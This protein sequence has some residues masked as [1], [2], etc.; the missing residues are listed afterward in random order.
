SREDLERELASAL[1]AAAGPQARR[2]ALNAFKDR[3]MFRVDMRHILGHIREFARFSD[4]LSDLAE[5]VVAAATQMC[6]SELAAQHGSPMLK[7]GGP[8]PYAVCA[9]GKCGG[10]ELGFASDIELMYLY[11]GEGKST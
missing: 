4:E 11:A 10:R 8:V 6:H 7:E 2:A 1:A 3:E 5:I 9:L